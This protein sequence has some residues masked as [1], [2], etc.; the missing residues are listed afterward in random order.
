MPPAAALTLLVRDAGAQTR[1]RLEAHRALI[2]RLARLETIG[3]A[4]AVPG[5]AAQA[6]LD[7][8]TLILPLAD[9]IDL[10]RERERLG[11]EIAKVDAEIAK[12]DGKLANPQFRARAPEAVVAEQQSRRD[13]YADTRERLAAALARVTG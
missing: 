7:E 2:G 9:V 8:A 11:R 3:E 13:G 6:V 12:I 10:D 5:G 1:R 4:A